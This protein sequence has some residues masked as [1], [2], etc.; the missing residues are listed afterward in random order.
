MPVYERHYKT[1]QAFVKWLNA[2]GMVIAGPVHDPALGTNV[3]A[4]LQ[5]SDV[6]RVCKD[7][8]HDHT[9]ELE[10]LPRPAITEKKEPVR[11]FCSDG[12]TIWQGTEVPALWKQMYC[13]QCQDYE[14]GYNRIH[15]PATP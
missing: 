2:H 4:E 6:E 7:F 11:V 12:H 1:A 10:S 13:D 15:P 3:L 5:D 9:A 8:D 14:P